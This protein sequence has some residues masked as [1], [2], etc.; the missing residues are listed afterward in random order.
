M[1]CAEQTAVTH[2]RH[3]LAKATQIPY[4]RDYTHLRLNLCHS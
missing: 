4:N 1:H 2:E 3:T